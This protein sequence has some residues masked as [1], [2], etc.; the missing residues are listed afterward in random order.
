MWLA[1][2]IAAATIGMQDPQP[3]FA[4]AYLD[5]GARELVRLARER[6]L[7]AERSI[8]RYEALAR[9]RISLGIQALRRERMIYR[10]ETAARID[11]RRDGTVEMELLGAREAFPI[12]MSEAGLPHSLRRFARYLAFDPADLR[13]SF[14][15]QGRTGAAGND[16]MSHPLAPGS[17]ADYRFASGDTTVIQLPD[18]RSVRLIELRVIPRRR[19]FRLLSGSFWFEADTY[20]LVQATFRLARPF[21]LERDGDPED[22]RNMWPVVRGLLLPIRADVRYITIE[23]GLWDM[24]WWMPRLVALEGVAEVGSFMRTPLR[25]E[26]EYR[27]YTVYGELLDPEVADTIRVGIPRDSLSGPAENVRCRNQR[28]HVFHVRIPEDSLSLLASEHLPGSIYD[29][30]SAF[31]TEAELRGLAERLER[32]GDGPWQLEAPRLSW[33]LGRAGLVRYNRVEGLSV[34]ARLDADFGRLTADATVRYGFADREVNGELGMVRPTRTMDYRLGIYRRLASADPFSHP[35]GLGNSFTALVFGRDDGEYFRALGVELTGT[36][37]DTRDPWFTWRVF[38][39]RQ[40]PAAVGTAF[41]VR[42]LIDEDHTFRPNIVAD[43][44]DQV[45]A[46]VTLRL[47]RGLDPAAFRWSAAASIEAATG[48]FRYVKPSATVWLGVPLGG[49]FLGALEVSAGTTVGD[50]PVQSLWYLG[51]PGTLRGYDGGAARGEA[52]W[53]GRAEL[54]TAFPGARVAAFVDAGRA[55]PRR[56]LRLDPTLVSAGVGVS[57]LDGLIRLDL[58]RALRDPVRWRFDMYVDAAL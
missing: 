9:E 34:G 40:T 15:M 57:F 2:V 48:D 17:E 12:A 49:P 8:E 54:G 41:S 1:I 35:F 37:A 56:D 5:P 20:A 26:L 18:G 27:D 28:C 6:R 33:G 14:E 42:R 24:Q 7:T 50:V 4:D 52:F 16:D 38:A 51:G 30:G 11:W 23:Y 13:L 29:E 21:D 44:A 32:I 22:V 58:A 10:R 3:T 43:S 53:R 55:G 36:S 25:Y 19:E 31:L 45:G 47:D 39:E 46:A